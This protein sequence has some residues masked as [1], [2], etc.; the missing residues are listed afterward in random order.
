MPPNSS[1][2]E[3]LRA[4]L[5]ASIAAE[6]RLLA[7]APLQARFAAAQAGINSAQAQVVDAE[8]TVEAAQA[9]IDSIIASINSRAFLAVSNWCLTAEK[10]DSSE[11]PIPKSL[12][13]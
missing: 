8:A 1:P 7:D 13:F 4:N 10:Q 11:C 12:R 9:S 6:Q 2:S 5:D 3:R